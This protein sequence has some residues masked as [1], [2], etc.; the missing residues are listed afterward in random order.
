MIVPVFDLGNVLITV[1]KE[2]TADNLNTV[3]AGAGDQFIRLLRVHPEWERNLETGIWSSDEFLAAVSA[4]LKEK[5][6]AEDLARA[7]S[8]IFTL[9]NDVI[10]LLPRLKERHSLYLLSNTNEIHVKYGFG[11]YPIFHFFD[12][13]IM[14]HRVGAA[15][16]DPAIYRYVENRTGAPP[17]AHLLIDDLIENVRGAERCGWDA[18]QFTGYDELLSA[19]KSRGLI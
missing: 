7:Y 3:R 17:E 12:E 10:N 9:K 8:D 19:L 16:P 18:L 1:E 6:T 4:A 5:V 14:S 2:R 15:K 13:L 11:G